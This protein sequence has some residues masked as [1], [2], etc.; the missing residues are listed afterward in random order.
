VKVVLDTNVIVSALINPYGAPA[1][2]LGLVLEEKIELC[3]DTRILIE[4]RDV[5][6]RPKFGFVQ[7]EM[8][9]WNTLRKLDHF[10]LRP[11]LPFD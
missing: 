4:Y 10:I 6:M 2:I 11:T 5:V 8:D 7:T 1:S 9:Y 3:Y